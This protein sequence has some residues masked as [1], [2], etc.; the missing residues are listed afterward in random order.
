LK[1]GRIPHLVLIDSRAAEAFE[2]GNASLR[3][4]YAAFQVVDW[5]IAAVAAQ[6]SKGA[7]SSD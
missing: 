1:E 3:K 6:Q 4:P 5:A 7:D 2:A